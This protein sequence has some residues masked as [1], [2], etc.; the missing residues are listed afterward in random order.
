MEGYT[1]IVILKVVIVYELLY[2]VQYNYRK[3]VHKKTNEIN[4]YN[5]YLY[6]VL[7]V[8]DKKKY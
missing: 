2:C 1:G 6:F 3:P 5:K 4:H 7:T 8:I